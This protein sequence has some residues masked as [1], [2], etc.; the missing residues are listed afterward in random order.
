[1]GL[2]EWAWT[3]L[4]LISFIPLSSVRSH[5]SLA[6]S[7]YNKGLY[8]IF[9]ETIHPLVYTAP[10]LE[11]GWMWPKF[12]DPGFPQKALQSLILW[13]RDPAAPGEQCSQSRNDFWKH[14]KCWTWT[15][16]VWMGSRNKIILECCHSKQNK[17]VQTH[18]TL[19]RAI[20]ID[21]VFSMRSKNVI[22][23]TGLVLAR[24]SCHR[25]KTGKLQIY[26]RVFLPTDR[27]LFIQY[28]PWNLKGRKSIASHTFL[29][30]LYT[31][32]RRRVAFLVLQ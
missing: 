31:E 12:P 2:V 32:Q 3:S 7:F 8:K 9:M 21:P 17:K 25:L 23:G 4:I 13:S 30:D 14:K 27:S 18:E 24:K 26:C 16:L 29:P 22:C 19:P 6:P 20:R 10:E 5:D 1:M 11:I 28:C 15:W